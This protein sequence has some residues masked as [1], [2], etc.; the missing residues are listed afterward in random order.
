MSAF[1]GKADMTY[2]DGRNATARF[3][4]PWSGV[5][6]FNTGAEKAVAR[7][8]RWPRQIHL[9]NSRTR[10]RTISSK[11]HRAASTFCRLPTTA[12]VPCATSSPM[13]REPWQSHASIISGSGRMQF[14]AAE[15]KAFII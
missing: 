13:P 3:R 8:L 11:R 5:R 7:E 12:N 14:T 15:A 9:R 4:F 10:R 2:C 6:L 1:G